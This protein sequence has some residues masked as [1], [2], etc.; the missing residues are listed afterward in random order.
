VFEVFETKIG[1]PEDL[2]SSPITIIKIAEH[3]TIS[4]LKYALLAS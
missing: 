3:K 2:Q 4:D 1:T